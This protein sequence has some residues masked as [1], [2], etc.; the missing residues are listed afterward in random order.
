MPEVTSTIT[1]GK[2]VTITGVTGARSCT[3]TNSANEIDVTALGNTSRKFRRGIVEQT[4][5]IECVDVPGVA[6]GGSFTIAGTS[7][8]NATYVC[9]SV[10]RDE[11]LDGIVTFTVSGTRTA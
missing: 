4:I 5:E 11:P 1:L 9:T 8:G 7:T 10:K 6:A 3:V 2:N